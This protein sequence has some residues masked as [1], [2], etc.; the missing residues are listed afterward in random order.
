MAALGSSTAYGNT[1][2]Q[3]TP[4]L[5]VIHEKLKP[6]EYEGNPAYAL[7]KKEEAFGRFV[8]LPVRYAA[9][10]DGAAIDTVAFST[11]VS[12]NPSYVEFQ[13]TPGRDYVRNYL[14]GITMAVS[15][16]DKQAV[17]SNIMAT[18]NA[19]ANTAARS[20]AVM[21]FGIGN[22]VRGQLS[23]STNLATTTLQ[24][25]DVEQIVNFEVGMRIQLISANTLTADVRGSGSYLTVTK[26]DRGA[27]SMVLNNAINT[28]TGATTSDFIVRYGD[29]AYDNSYAGSGNPVL[30]VGVSGWVPFSAPSATTFYS[31]DRTTDTRL[32]GVRITG[33]GRDK[34]E[35]M[36]KAIALSRREGAFGKKF[37]IV[38]P[39]DFA[40]IQINRD[41]KAVVT[42]DLGGKAKVSFSA[43]EVAQNGGEPVM[44]LADRGWPRGYFHLLQTDTWQFRSAGKFHRLLDEDGRYFLR[45]AGADAYEI[46]QGGYGTF[47][48]DAPAYNVAGTW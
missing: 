17:I 37:F 25:R 34:S 16:G 30:P 42:V 47:G 9:S 15:Q 14:S 13:L 22:G 21:T 27:G 6:I 4:A 32:S 31:V 7:M 10:P 35:T 41:A 26:I 24:L 33:G 48:C 46:R 8:S 39:M 28:L 2:A 43:I 19:M 12:G 38:N 1:I 36:I 18:K 5:K 3:F 23:T 29:F 44:V 40:D 45:V 11:T 20:I